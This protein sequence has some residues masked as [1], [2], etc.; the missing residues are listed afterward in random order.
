MRHT[1]ISAM[2]VLVALAPAGMAQFDGWPRSGVFHVLTTPEGA[3]LPESAE[4][5]DFPVLVRLDRD[6][7]DFATAGADGREVTLVRWG[8]GGGVEVMRMG[9][10]GA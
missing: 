2:T 10:V 9:G 6:G 8:G 1:L 5:K 7:F 4:V 3:N